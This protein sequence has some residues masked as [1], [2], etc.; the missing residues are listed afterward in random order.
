[1]NSRQT[2]ILQAH[3]LFTDTNSSPAWLSSTDLGG[4]HTP[5]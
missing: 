5:L 1:M 3:E 2:R 4:L